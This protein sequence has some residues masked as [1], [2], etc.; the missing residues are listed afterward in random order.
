MKT[1]K[2]QWD[3][4]TAAM[5]R[6]YRATA[7]AHRLNAIAAQACRLGTEADYAHYMDL[8]ADYER[9]AEESEREIAA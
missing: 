8:A 6:V 5:V 7:E 2:Q 4:Y 9:M 1:T 3:A